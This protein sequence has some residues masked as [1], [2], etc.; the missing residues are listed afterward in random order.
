M[1]VP[2][3]MALSGVLVDSFSTSSLFIFSGLITAALG[4]RMAASAKIKLLYAQQ[5]AA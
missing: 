1:L 4:L 2:L 5:D 3:S